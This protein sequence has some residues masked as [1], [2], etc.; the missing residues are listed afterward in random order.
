MDPAPP[1][2]LDWVEPFVRSLHE[3]DER[4]V[5][6]E[7][8]QEGGDPLRWLLRI[9]LPVGRKWAEPYRSGARDLVKVWAAANECEYKRTT[10]NKRVMEVLILVKHPSRPSNKDPY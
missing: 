5:G 10:Y 4:L 3:A 6:W 7:L 8:A 9:Y 1:R 2:A